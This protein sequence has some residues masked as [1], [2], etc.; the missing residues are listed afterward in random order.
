[1][2]GG[3]EKYLQNFGWGNLKKRDLWKDLGVGGN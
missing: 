1:M 3:E 2:R